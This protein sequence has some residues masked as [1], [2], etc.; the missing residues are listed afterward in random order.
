[1]SDL[2]DLRHQVSQHTRRIM[3]IN[4]SNSTNSFNKSIPGPKFSNASLNIDTLAQ[5]QSG[6]H[7]TSE[8]DNIVKQ[9]Y[10]SHEPISIQELNNLGSIDLKELFL[11]IPDELFYALLR[12]RLKLPNLEESK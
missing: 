8:N 4:M 2:V 3:G 6:K 10:T 1:M 7:T 11:K 9:Q 5:V 12:I